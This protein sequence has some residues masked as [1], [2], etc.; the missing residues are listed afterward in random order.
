MLT[1][2]GFVAVSIMF[3]SYWNE[4]RSKWLVLVFAIGCGLTSLYSGLA[5][6]YT[7]T[8]IEGLWALIALKRFVRRHI[9]ENHHFQTE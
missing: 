3:L 1:T 2:F 6:V 9:T 4:E 5:E 8:V 7:V